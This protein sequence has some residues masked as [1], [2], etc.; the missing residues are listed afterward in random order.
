M[1]SCSQWPEWQ[2]GHFGWGFWDRQWWDRICHP[3]CQTHKLQHWNCQCKLG[4]CWQL[5][6]GQSYCS[7]HCGQRNCAQW[8]CHQS[9]WR[10]LLSCHC[11]QNH[12]EHQMLVFRQLLRRLHRGVGCSWSVRSDTAHNRR[13]TAYRLFPHLG[14]RKA[15]M[16]WKKK[17]ILTSKLWTEGRQL[18]PEAL[19]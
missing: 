10:P 15:A 11:Q 14:R 9:M 1:D 6:S 12:S 4:H 18:L 7:H 13:C 16:E 17:G 3:L 19:E 5:H 8:L 2:T